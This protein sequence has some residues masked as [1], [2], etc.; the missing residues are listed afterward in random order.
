[1]AAELPY[2]SSYKN[3]A[4]LFQKIATAKQPETFTT[5][6]LSDT[7][8]LKSTGD[9]QLITLLKALGFIDA[10]SRPTPEYGSLKN[11]ARAGAAI[12][13]A[14][15]RTYEPLFAAN[16]KVYALS[17]NELRGLVAQVAGSDT[18]MTSKIAGTFTSLVRLADFTAPSEENGTPKE[19]DKTTDQPPIVERPQQHFG[20]LRP[21]FH[22]NIQ[23]HLPANATEETYLNIF[24]A[25][26]KAFR[27]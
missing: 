12:A 11:Q 6:Y 2:L 17:S 10:A 3:V 23:V 21:E 1:M 14:V 5:R 25:L 8:G 15:K 4:E 19:P 22:Y 9:R 18:G 27:P 13:A 7:L 24:N 26:R 20:A 16:E